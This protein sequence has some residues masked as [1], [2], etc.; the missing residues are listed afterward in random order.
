MKYEKLF[1]V[2]RILDER[3]GPGDCQRPVG[4]PHEHRGEGVQTGGTW[5][6]SVNPPLPPMLMGSPRESLWE[7][8]GSHGK[9]KH[10]IPKQGGSWNPSC[11]KLGSRPQGS[12][13]GQPLHA[14]ERV[15]E[16]RDLPTAP[17]ARLA[18]GTREN[19]TN[20]RARGIA[21]KAVQRSMPQL[22]KGQQGRR[23]AGDPCNT[24]ETTEARARS[25]KPQHE[26]QSLQ[27]CRSP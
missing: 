10:A 8:S 25:R 23:A 11:A 20:N 18:I 22:R 5:G 7:P 26:L 3:Q 15:G 6:V 1:D 4:D 17:R 12:E 19:S 13:L 27:G 16:L 21:T 24:A 9:L 14:S 2:L